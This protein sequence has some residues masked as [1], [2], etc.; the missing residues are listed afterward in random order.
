MMKTEH[1]SENEK[2]SKGAQVF[3]VLFSILSW[4]MVLALLARSWFITVSKT[5]YWDKPVKEDKALQLEVK[6]ETK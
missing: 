2:Y 5:G 3:G 4:V 1:E 6:Q